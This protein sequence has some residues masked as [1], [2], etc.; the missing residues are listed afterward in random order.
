MVSAICFSSLLS[1]V[2]FLSSISVSPPKSKLIVDEG[3]RMLVALHNPIQLFG[4][5]KM[6]STFFIIEIQDLSASLLADTD[7]SDPR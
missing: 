2:S 3:F 5:T 7:F 4:K 1:F 6:F